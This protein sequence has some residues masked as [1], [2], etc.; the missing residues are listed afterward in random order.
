VE[1]AASQQTDSLVEV[2]RIVNRHGIRGELRIRLHNSESNLL[3]AIERLALVSPDGAVEWRRIIGTRRHKHFILTRFDGV[4]DA[5][6]AELLIGRSVAVRRDQLP[7]AEEGEVY[8]LDLLDCSVSTDAGEPLGRVVDVIVTGSN[9]VCVVRDG[10]R[11]YLIPLIDDVIV[12]L[13]PGEKI[14]VRPIPGL[15]DP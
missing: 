14:V 5:N 4:D 11:E 1:R 9:D 8:H 2:G 10:E 12:E 3:A 15:L 7:E 6:S 13:S